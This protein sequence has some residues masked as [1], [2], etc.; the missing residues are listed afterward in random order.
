MMKPKPK[1]LL[2]KP[3]LSTL[4]MESISCGLK[5]VDRWILWRY[6]PRR[7]ANGST[8]WVKLPFKCSGQE[9]K[10]CGPDTWLT[11]SAAVDAFFSG[12]DNGE[13]FEGLGFVGLCKDEP[14]PYALVAKRR[15]K[16]VTTK[17][18]STVSSKPTGKPKKGAA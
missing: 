17:A 1:H 14:N 9:A 3:G 8:Q 18:H 10:H 16:P 5:D 15:R 12:D 2:P 13:S 7:R 4:R 6:A 11:F